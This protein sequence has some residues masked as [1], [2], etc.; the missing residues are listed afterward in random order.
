MK[1]SV[2]QGDNYLTTIFWAL[3]AACFADI[4]LIAITVKTYRLIRDYNLDR[5]HS[6]VGS[7]LS[8]ILLALFVVI[9]AV[10]FNIRAGRKITEMAGVDVAQVQ[11]YVTSSLSASPTS[12]S[13]TPQA[14]AQPSSTQESD[15][16][17]SVKVEHSYLGAPVSG[18]N[19]RFR[20]SVNGTPVGRAAKNISFSPG[21]VLYLQSSVI[22]NESE[23]RLL[24]RKAV[25]STHQAFQF[26]LPL[27]D[28]N[29]A[30]I[31][32]TTFY[33]QKVG[34]PTP[35]PASVNYAVEVTQQE[36]ANATPEPS[37]TNFATPQP[38]QPS[39]QSPNSTKDSSS[40]GADST[41]TEITGPLSKTAYWVPNGKSYHFRR[42]CP[43]LSRSDV[44][45]SG[46]LQDAL[47]AGKTDP[48]NNCAY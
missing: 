26:V 8:G 24:S 37:Q 14:D 32:Q 46:T 30:V 36:K 23:G 17:F 40:W 6:V 43:S 48:C 18:T 20:D 22:A 21:T 10:V 9:F 3:L 25:S 38:S 39:S 41:T 5:G 4:F 2:N 7:T 42:S 47:D 35:D 16:L 15:D 19:Y 28:E 34:A 31:C 27:C 44:V 13:P 12:S 33:F 1:I 11:S 29:G 45:Y